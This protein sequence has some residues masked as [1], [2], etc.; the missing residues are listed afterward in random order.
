M[1]VGEMWSVVVLPRVLISTGMSRKSLPSQAAQGWMT[2][3]RSLAGSIARSMER[4]S[5]GGGT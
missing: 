1:P 4:P 2:W 3:R 5:A